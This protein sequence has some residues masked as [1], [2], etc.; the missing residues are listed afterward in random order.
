MGYARREPQI[1]LA[2]MAAQAFAD[3]S[4]AA[5]EAGTGTGK[6]LGYLAPAALYARATGRPVAVSTFTRV[7]QA[8]L[9]ERELPLVQQLVPGL[10]YALLQGRANYLSLSRL[11]EEIIDALGY[12][13]E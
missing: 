3:G 11:A 8:Q 13:Q 9:V 4:F 6:S 12:G 10:T 7:L 1:E 2:H 5:I